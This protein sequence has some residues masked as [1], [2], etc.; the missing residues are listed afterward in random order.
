MDTAAGQRGADTMMSH[1]KHFTQHR[2]SQAVRSAGIV[3][4]QI[5]HTSDGARDC[6]LQ[7]QTSCVCI[8]KCGLHLFPRLQKQALPVWGCECA[9]YQCGVWKSGCKLS[10]N[11]P[12]WLALNCSVP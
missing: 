7:P 3:A 2:E 1:V 9:E 10:T 6:R 11:S 12:C 8:T 5:P 4:V